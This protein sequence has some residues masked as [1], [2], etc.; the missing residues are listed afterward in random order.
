MGLQ[1]SQT[2]LK[3][4]SMMHLHH[5]FIWD[6]LCNHKM[7]MEKYNCV[8]FLPVVSIFEQKK[9]NKFKI[10][11]VRITW[12]LP[13]SFILGI[14]VCLGDS[15]SLRVLLCFSEYRENSACS[16]ALLHILTSCVPRVP[17]SSLEKGS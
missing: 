14:S 3:Q 16:F 7:G 9:K 6:E 1:K 12:L 17:M 4:L 5:R 8:L 15:L 11:Q 10:F 13:V 2:R